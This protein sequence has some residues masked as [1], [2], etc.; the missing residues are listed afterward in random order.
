MIPSCLLKNPD[1]STCGCKPKLG[2]GTSNLWSHV[3]VH[4]KETFLE[5][6]RKLGALTDVGEECLKEL[7][8]A[9]KSREVENEV[10]PT[11]RTL[12]K[13]AQALVTRL[14]AKVVVADDLAFNAFESVAMKA[15][16]RALT[17]NAVSGVGR[18]TIA[19]EVS[20]LSVLGRDNATEFVKIL[21]DKEILITLSADLWSKNGVALLGILAHGILRKRIVDSASAGPGP[22]RYKWCMVEK[23]V[24]ALPCKEV[25]HTGEW[26]FEATTASL[27]KAGMDTPVHQVFRAKTD[28]AS[29]MISGYAELK[30]DPCAC[31]VIETDVAVFVDH[32]DLKAII[33][34]GRGTVAYFNTSTI[35]R[36]KL[37]KIMKALGLPENSL[38]RDV[39]TRWRSTYDMAKCLGTN[40]FPLLQFDVQHKDP[41]E[42]YTKNKLTVGEFEILKQI[43]A[44]LWPISEASTVLEGK[45]YPTSNLVL[46]YIYA[47]IAGLADASPTRREDMSFITT[48]ELHMDV[49]EARKNL[50]AALMARW[51]TG[52]DRNQLLFFYIATLLDPRFLALRIP[53]FTNEMRKEA[54]AALR[55]EYA[56]NWAPPAPTETPRAPTREEESELINNGCALRDGSLESFMSSMGHL[57]DSPAS[58]SPTASAKKNEIE[59]Y[60]STE[61]DG[62]FL[63]LAPMNYKPLE[64]WSANEHRFPRLS[65]MALQYLGCP[66]TSASAE[67]TFSLAGR[68]FSDLR[69]SMSDVSLEERMWAKINREPNK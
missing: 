33:V 60:L 47:A 22:V 68:L 67:R 37:K 16:D 2:G 6:K 21:L 13:D 7:K 62:V 59:E 35:S 1:G 53:L 54:Y 40:M 8:E 65:R 57:M 61:S 52:I 31:H 48:D 26:I 9:F 49:R 11:I 12:G 17:D 30:H 20:C 41:T 56:M 18:K 64:W 25:S 29:N 24:A 32:E 5:L 55:N 38:I 39:C 69:Q 58:T 34:K 27:S 46:V 43:A 19:S 14:T 23:L 63:H 44:V 4:H 15:R 45:N 51:V 50:H 66:A 3:Q 36:S 28:R 42:A 10:S